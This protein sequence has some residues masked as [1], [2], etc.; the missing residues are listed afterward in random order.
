M[1]FGKSSLLTLLFLCFYVDALSG[2]TVN[3]SN[4]GKL[5]EYRDYFFPE[6]VEATQVDLAEPKADLLTIIQYKASQFD[7]VLVDDVSLDV[8]GLDIGVNIRWFI[9][10]LNSPDYFFRKCAFTCMVGIRKE[11]KIYVY[12]G[13]VQ[14]T[15]VPPRGD[16][17]GFGR[18]FLPDG[19]DLT[20]GEFMNP[21]YNARYIAVKNFKADT[22]FAILPVLEQW[23]GEFQN[24]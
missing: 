8:E 5:Q 22:P 6:T 3:T 1:P 12:K 14:G 19:A 2:V 21:Q 13:D 17:F 16:C 9:S 11:D 15:L 23:P 24:E 4:K 18:Y 10:Q 7:G 20:L